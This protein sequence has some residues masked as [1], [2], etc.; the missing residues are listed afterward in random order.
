MARRIDKYHMHQSTEF[1]V[2]FAQLY[3]VA[4]ATF[5][6]GKL[7]RRR[8]YA[9]AV[10]RVGGKRYSV[11][12]I[13]HTSLW[14]HC[15]LQKLPIWGSPPTGST[16]HTFPVLS[17]NSDRIKSCRQKAV[18]FSLPPGAIVI[19]CWQ[20]QVILSWHVGGE[21]CVLTSV[22][23]VSTLEH[24]SLAL[25]ACYEFHTNV[26]GTSW[27]F[28]TCMVLILGPGLTCGWCES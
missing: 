20:K 2:C 19:I 21:Q 22:G 13:K 24:T 3:R 9:S 10:C 8:V 18:M 6:S 27:N 1:K 28:H 25:G 17:S 15:D 14:F 5:C 23:L 26:L 7:I 11:S 4:K 12:T 16:V